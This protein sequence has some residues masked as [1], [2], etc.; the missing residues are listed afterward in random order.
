MA[1]E[2][3]YFKFEP[4]EWENGNIQMC[5]TISKGLFIDI[6]SIY[7][8]RI[9]ELPYALALQ[10]LCRGD[11]EL[12]KELLGHDIIRV[13]ND[14]IIIDFLDEQLQE[15][16]GISERRKDAANQR[17]KNNTENANAMQL[18]SK[19]N[20]IREEEIREEEIREEKKRVDKSKEEKKVIDQN[21][22]L[23]FDEFWF[24]YDKKEGRAEALKVWMKIDLEK[25]A[26][27]IEK[28]V[29]YVNS[30]P[31][32]KFRKNPKTYLNGQ[33]WEDEIIIYK[34]QQNATTTN[35]AKPTITDRN[36]ATLERF[37]RERE[38]FLKSQRD[39]NQ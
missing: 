2:L 16:K 17:W 21:K 29:P 11:A 9:G 20:A 14:F 38:E 32:K 18:H 26:N 6:C 28:V 5:S 35:F 37:D 3:P 27:I 33:H 39:F 1:K 25:M 4:S 31:D 34:P 30:T 8:A 15:F 7:W 12:M 24:N 22:I 36:K 23:L 19:S 10:K 13:E